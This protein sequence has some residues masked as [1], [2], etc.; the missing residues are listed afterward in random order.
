M[1]VISE[2]KKQYSAKADAEKLLEYADKI[3]NGALFKK[4]GFIAEFHQFEAW[5]IK[6][7]RKRLTEG[8][9]SLDKKAKQTQLVTRWKLWVPKEYGLD[10]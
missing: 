2:Y 7:C 8:Y 4:L 1:D 9:A 10:D 3:G 6:E 5:F